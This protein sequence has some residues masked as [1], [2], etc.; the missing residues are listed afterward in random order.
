M[1]LSQ[2]VVTIRSMPA[3]LKRRDMNARAPP[4]ATPE[5]LRTH[6]TLIKPVSN[7]PPLRSGQHVGKSSPDYPC[8]LLTCDDSDSLG[9]AFIG[10]IVATA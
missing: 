1:L 10:V 6:S 5:V 2:R 9:A 4:L 7:G 3:A 8:N